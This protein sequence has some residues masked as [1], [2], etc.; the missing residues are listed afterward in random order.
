MGLATV[1]GV[2]SWSYI[3]RRQFI[4]IDV[5]GRTNEIDTIR[6]SEAIS[7]LT[8]TNIHIVNE[9]GYRIFDLIDFSTMSADPIVIDNQVA[10]RAIGLFSSIILMLYLGGIFLWNFIARLTFL[11]AIGV[12]I[13]AV[14]RTWREKRGI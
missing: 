1:D 7:F 9:D 14:V 3:Q 12:V 5:T 2:Q 6:F 4:G 10:G 13:W 8:R 11:G